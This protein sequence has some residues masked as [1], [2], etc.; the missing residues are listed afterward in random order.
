MILQRSQTLCN[1]RLVIYRLICFIEIDFTKMAHSD[2]C[3]HPVD[4]VEMVSS[5]VNDLT[6]KKRP[7]KKRRET[8]PVIIETTNIENAVV[9][10]ERQIL[11]EKVK[12]LTDEELAMLISR[13]TKKSNNIG[14]STGFNQMKF[15]SD[16]FKEFINDVRASKDDLKQQFLKDHEH[17][18]NHNQ[19]TRILVG[20]MI[21]TYRDKCSGTITKKKFKISYKKSKVADQQV[22]HTKINCPL[23]LKLFSN[24]LDKLV[25]DGQ[26]YYISET[27]LQQVLGNAFVP[28]SEKKIDLKNILAA[29]NF[30]NDYVTQKFELED[31]NHMRC[32]IVSGNLSSKVLE[33][34]NEHVQNNQSDLISPIKSMFENRQKLFEERKHQIHPHLVQDENLMVLT[35]S[36]FQFICSFM[37]KQN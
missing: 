27:S 37:F 18:L 17:F 15:Y 25:F 10:R 29:N 3:V 32:V 8:R 14:M 1:K 20:Q 5:K 33:T 22:E 35:E 24:D 4:I 16:K 19:C 13:K 23:L 7:Q 26:D 2:P 11:D 6:V 9:S 36:C 21:R 34:F 30:S 12:S 31:G 28:S